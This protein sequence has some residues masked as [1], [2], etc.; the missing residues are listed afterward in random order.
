M[1]YRHIGRLTIWLRCHLVAMLLDRT[2]SF[3]IDFLA[4]IAA[5]T[6]RKMKDWSDLDNLFFFKY[7]HHRST[8]NDDQK[9]LMEIDDLLHRLDLVLLLEEQRTNFYSGWK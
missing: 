1:G 6:G 4:Q 3:F 9:Q 2:R 7:F 8:Y 5:V